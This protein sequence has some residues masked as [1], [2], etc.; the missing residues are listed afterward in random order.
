[1]TTVSIRDCFGR[2]REATIFPDG[3]SWTCPFCGNG[4]IPSRQDRP[5]CRNPWCPAVPEADNDGARTRFM[6]AYHQDAL[7]MEEMRRHAR[8]AEW[9]RER[10]AEDRATA[11]RIRQERIEQARQAGQCVRCALEYRPRWIRHRP[12][13]AHLT[14]GR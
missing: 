3:E 14:E 5:A 12:G 9:T 2:T 7:M 4:V 10:I 8:V 1:M 13:H 11:V 6:D